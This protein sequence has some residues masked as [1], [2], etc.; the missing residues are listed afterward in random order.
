MSKPIHQHEDYMAYM[1]VSQWDFMKR[2]SVRDGEIFYDTGVI[3]HPISDR[4]KIYEAFFEKEPETYKKELDQLK[5]DRVR[6]KEI[7]R[8]SDNL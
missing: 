5:K 3:L 4:I 6:Q 2:L 7:L 1:H 8:S